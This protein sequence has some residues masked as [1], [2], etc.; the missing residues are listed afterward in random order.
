MRTFMRTFAAGYHHA[1]ESHER[2]HVIRAHNGASV[3]IHVYRPVSYMSVLKVIYY[4]IF[5]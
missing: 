1:S 2:D 5:F 4:F 3:F